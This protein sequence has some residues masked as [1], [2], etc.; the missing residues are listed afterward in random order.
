MV[1]A[2]KD[3]SLGPDVQ[4]RLT[5]PRLTEGRLEILPES[6]HLV[7]LEASEKLVELLRDFANSDG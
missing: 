7:P 6:G 1:A 3:K 5:M 2:G 4:Q